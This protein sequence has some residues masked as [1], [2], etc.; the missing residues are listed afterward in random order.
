MYLLI[1]FLYFMDILTR[2]TQRIQAFSLKDM[3]IRALIW[4]QTLIDFGWK[5]VGVEKKTGETVVLAPV[6]VVS[7]EKCASVNKTYTFTVKE[8]P[9]EDVV[10]PL[11]KE[12][13]AVVPKKKRGRKPKAIAEPAI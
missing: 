4:A 5:I 9:V 12:E 11:I 1:L 2:I 8:D 7:K 6:N 10:T 3:F 13:A